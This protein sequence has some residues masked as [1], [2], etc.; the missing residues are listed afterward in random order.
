MDGRTAGASSHLLPDVEV[1]EEAAHLP[2]GQGATGE[3]VVVARQQVHAQDL[4]VAAVQGAART[5][6]R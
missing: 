2:F 6:S 5:H 4:D 3:R 1:A